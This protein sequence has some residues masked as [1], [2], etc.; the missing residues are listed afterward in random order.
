MKKFDGRMK[1]FDGRNVN[2]RNVSDENKQWA[3]SGP[4]DEC[5]Q[6]ISSARDEEHEPPL[7]LPASSYQ[8]A[9]VNEPSAEAKEPDQVKE[10]QLLPGGQLAGSA[11]EKTTSKKKKKSTE[12]ASDIER[13]EADCAA[14]LH[15]ALESNATVVLCSV[16]GIAAPTRI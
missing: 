11:V 6:V 3:E 12:E 1:K 5:L 13:E 2:G 16:C 10:V 7:T 9:E 14:P 15:D 8:P 4:D